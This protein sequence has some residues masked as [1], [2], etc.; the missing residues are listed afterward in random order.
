MTG[1]EGIF[2]GG[3]TMIGYY[4][5]QEMVTKTYGLQ[6]FHAGFV[7]EACH[8]V[9]HV[10][11]FAVCFC[12]QVKEKKHKQQNIYTNYSKTMCSSE[13]FLHQNALQLSMHQR[14]TIAS[15]SYD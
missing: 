10:V 1:L 15:Y 6:S 11:L 9:V 14:A 2:N 13:L 8:S 5:F 12:W 4:I 3:K 7:T